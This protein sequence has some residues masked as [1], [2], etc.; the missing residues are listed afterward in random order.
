MSEKYFVFMEIKQTGRTFGQLIDCRPAKERGDLGN[1]GE[2]LHIHP[3]DIIP[4]SRLTYDVPNKGDEF[5]AINSQ[6][7]VLGI[8]T[9]G[10]TC[11]APRIC[12][13]P[14]VPES[15]PVN[16]FDEWAD[17]NPWQDQGH[18]DY[19]QQIVAITEWFKR[20]PKRD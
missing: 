3:D 16:E 14:P 5:L 11:N 15:K 13:K 9:A 1:Y 6:G 19:E 10:E 4:Q 20:M 8:H 17:N 18:K 7:N 12:I 2:V